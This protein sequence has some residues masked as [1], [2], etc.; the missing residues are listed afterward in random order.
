MYYNHHPCFPYSLAMIRY[1]IALACLVLLGACS[2]P[3]EYDVIIRNGVIYNGSGS[4]SYKGDLA[5]NGDTI[6]AVGSLGDAVGRMKL[7][8]GGLAIAP[9][10][11]NVLS[12]ATESLIEDG[13]SQGNIRQGVR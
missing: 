4:E 3:P 6:A 12:W 9:G 10:F 7:D 2:T 8:A 5:I 13:L 1:L 11:I